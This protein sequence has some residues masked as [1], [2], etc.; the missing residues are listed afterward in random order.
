MNVEEMYQ[1]QIL[2]HYRHPKNFGSIESPT[3]TFKDS[4]PSCGDIIEISMFVNKGKIEDIK[5]KGK[6]CAI[7]QASASMLT[8]FLKGKP[9]EEVKKLK[10]EDILEM[11]GIELSGIRLKCALLSLKVVKMG[12]YN[13]L[14]EKH[15]F[16]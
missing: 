6:G 12:V 9:L 7:S 16:A 10:K 5:F 14:G 3:L 1:E 11:L 13:Y 8:S 4:N 15:D 2:E